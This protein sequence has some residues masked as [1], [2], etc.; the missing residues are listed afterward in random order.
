MAFWFFLTLGAFLIIWVITG[1]HDTVTDS[2]LA[3]MGIGAGTALGV[4]VQD[5]SK[6]HT[7]EVLAKLRALS[8]QRADLVAKGTGTTDIDKQIA[9]LAPVS[10]GFLND[11]LTDANGISF[12]R[13][14]MFAWTLVLGVVF[15]K[16]VYCN[17]AMPEF[18]G[19]LLGLMGVSSGTYLGFMIPER[20]STDQ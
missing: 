9:A 5:K 7:S 10:E 6:E 18:S 3:L 11:I 8:Q 16:E 2:V 20:H 17:L 4:A 13:F 15:V 14:Q 12:H 1:A 19:T